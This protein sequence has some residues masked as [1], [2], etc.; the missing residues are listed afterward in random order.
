MKYIYITAVFLFLAS[1]SNEAI[2]T[3]LNDTTLN[4]ASTNTTRVEIVEEV[5]NIEEEYT[6]TQDEIEQEMLE[7]MSESE[8]QTQES[9]SEVV[10]Q[11]EQVQ[12]ES[13]PEIEV[14]ETPAVSGPSNKKAQ[15]TGSS[16]Y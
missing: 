16:G 3:T 7:L 4:D 10:E 12:I 13:E 5:S 1:C 8:V 14:I 9:R 6:S 15:R 11:E 2:D